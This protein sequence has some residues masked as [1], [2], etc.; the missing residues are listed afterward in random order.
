MVE[1]EKIPEKK[2][3]KGGEKG[4]ATTTSAELFLEAWQ[5][6]GQHLANDSQAPGVDFVER[7][8]RRVPVGVPYGKIDEGA[9]G[10]PPADG[11][12][13]IVPPYRTVFLYELFFVSPVS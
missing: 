12:E 7:V 4:P 8:L 3:Q 10:G 6:C 5:G 13:M 9:A 2:K 11:R 1:G